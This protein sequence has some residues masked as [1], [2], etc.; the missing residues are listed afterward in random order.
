MPKISISTKKS[1]FEPIEIEIDGETY[2]I[3]KVDRDLFKKINPLEPKKDASL[4][5]QVEAVYKQL[6]LMLNAPIK[7]V[8]RI[9]YRDAQHILNQI[10]REIFFAPTKRTNA[11]EPKKKIPKN[12]KN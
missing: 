1:L 8:E 12:P 7:K 11:K 4:P 10:S 3:E 6:A 2:S 9:D 5:K